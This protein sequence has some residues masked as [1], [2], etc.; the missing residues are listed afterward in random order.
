[1]RQNDI[2]LQ[3]NDTPADDLTLM[4][5]CEMI[6]ESGKHLRIYVKGDGYT[7]PEAADYTV[8]MWYRLREYSLVKLATI[9]CLIIL[10]FSFSA[11]KS[12]AVS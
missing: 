12:H 6:R 11:P 1:M 9:R 7:D 5:A 2:I 4:E 8:H 10:F 3:I